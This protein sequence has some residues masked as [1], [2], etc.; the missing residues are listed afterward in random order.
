MLQEK[1]TL[2]QFREPWIFIP[3][4]NEQQT[5]IL[6]NPGDYEELVYTRNKWHVKIKEQE[7]PILK[8]IMQIMKSLILIR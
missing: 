8:Y 2:I 5:V 3:D 6:V 1:E 7:W 4:F